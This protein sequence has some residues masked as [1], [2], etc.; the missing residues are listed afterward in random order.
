MTAKEG[1]QTTGRRT[2]FLGT[3]GVGTSQERECKERA[4]GTHSLEG[5]EGKA[6]HDTETR[7]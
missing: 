5:A 2:H 3:I 4:R 7:E 6:S 1:K